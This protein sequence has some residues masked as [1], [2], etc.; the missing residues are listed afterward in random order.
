M[1]RRFALLDRDGT[2]N[3]ERGYL[4]DPDDIELIPG[5]AD[6]LIRLHDEL[7]MGVV[8]VTNQAQIGRGH[9]SEARLA[10]IHERLLGMLDAKG[11]TVDAILHCPHAPEDDCSCRKPRPG[12]ALQAAERFGFDL[13]DAFVVGD[14]AADM[15]M[16][17]AVHATTIFVRT[18]HGRDEEE[19][20]GSMADH[21]ADDLP[22]AVAIIAG[23]LASDG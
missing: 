4:D 14:H 23:L 17:R 20:A 7:A 11:A 9:L 2:I 3:V 10:Q 5:V 18:G 8:V 19:A 6:A 22:G 15:G 1:S 16:G 21:L 13:G 12:L